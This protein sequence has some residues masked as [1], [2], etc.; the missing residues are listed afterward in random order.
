MRTLL[1][2]II[3][4][5]SLFAEQPP[6][7]TWKAHWIACPNAPAREAGVYRFRKSVNLASAPK[8]FKVH[9]S[10]DNRFILYV[11]GQRIGEGPARGDLFH[12]RYET[13]D[14]A[15]ALKP[16]DNVVSAL[17]WN[18]GARAPLAQMSNRTGFVL[19]GTS[20]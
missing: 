17:V 18:F 11:N 16:G 3:L 1:A 7:I 19:Q 2:V 15:P 20:P 5:S 6:T 4:A 10:A 12:W 13:F 8:A 9:V 14:L